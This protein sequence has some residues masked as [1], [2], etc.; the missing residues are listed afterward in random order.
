[1]CM[2][3]MCDLKSY[4]QAIACRNVAVQNGLVRQELIKYPYMKI[5]RTL[6]MV[7]DPLIT[8]RTRTY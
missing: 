1:M 8:F 7:E 3:C 4:T 2:A 5:W 6:R